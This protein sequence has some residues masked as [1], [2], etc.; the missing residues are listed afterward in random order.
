MKTEEQL[1]NAIE[2]LKEAMRDHH[3]LLLEPYETEAILKTYG[4]V[5]K[6]LEWVLSDDEK[7]LKGDIK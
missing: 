1:M 2:N 3:I 4:H 5:I 6:I 7:E